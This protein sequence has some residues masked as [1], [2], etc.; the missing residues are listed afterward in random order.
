MAKLTDTF[1]ENS[2]GLLYWFGQLDGALGDLAVKI[3]DCLNIA[4][5]SLFSN[6]ESKFDHR[7]SAMT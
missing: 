1:T 7:C 2:K 4:N 3:G 6:I 5:V